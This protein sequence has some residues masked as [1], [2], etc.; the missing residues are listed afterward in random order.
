MRSSKKKLKNLSKNKFNENR[1]SEK[2][3]ARPQNSQMIGPLPLTRSM[4]KLSHSKV[5]NYSRALQPSDEKK[6]KSQDQILQPMPNLRIQNL[7][8][9]LER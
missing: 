2:N 5:W 6:S 4:M 3:S 8:L 7:L 9:I 1:S